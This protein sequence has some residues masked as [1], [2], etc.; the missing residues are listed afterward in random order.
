MASVNLRG[1]GTQTLSSYVTALHVTL[2]PRWQP[3]R[4]RLGWR[5]VLVAITL[6]CP[7]FSHVAAPVCSGA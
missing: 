2:I 5:K 3:S 7:G 1:V 4:P 6:H